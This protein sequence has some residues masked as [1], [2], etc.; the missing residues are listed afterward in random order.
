M[1]KEKLFTPED[2]D[3]PTDKK[4]YQTIVAKIVFVIIALAIIAAAIIC[5]ISGKSDNEAHLTKSE[6]ASVEAVSSTTLPDENI[7]PTITEV[8]A[9]SVHLQEDEAVAKTEEIIETTT[10]P[11]DTQV[12]ASVV[13][14][15]TDSEALKVIRGDYGN[16]P[17]RK[18]LLGARY[19]EIQSRVNQ[20]KKEGKF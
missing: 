5:F 4:W 14:G 20:L 13:E 3:K 1:A 19:T 8:V 9:E 6:E 11:A 16:V 18:E 2:F 7:D 12:S 17:Q 10:G 15:S